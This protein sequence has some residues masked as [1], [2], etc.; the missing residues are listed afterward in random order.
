MSIIEIAAQPAEMT[1]RQRWSHYLAIAFAVIGAVIGINLRDTTLNATTLYA[2]PE[3]GIRAQFPQNWLLDE[4]G[5]YIFRVRDMSRPGYKTVLQVATRPVGPS[6]TIRSV[7]DALTLSRSQ[8]LSA[9]TVL[10]EEPFALPDEA[11]AS[12]MAYTFVATEPNPFL[13]GVPTVVRGL[14]I[15]TLKRGQAV[16]ITFQSDATTYQEDL[17]TLNLFVE[18]LEF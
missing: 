15:I 11:P 14:D 18:N 2:N 12:A 4:G 7:L 5:D 9:Y 16:V 1:F 17:S 8:T 10:S 3:A 13:R 6:T